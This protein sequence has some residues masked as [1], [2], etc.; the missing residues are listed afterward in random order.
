MSPLL[1]FVEH[2]LQEFA[3]AFMGTVYVFRLVWFFRRFKKPIELQ[4]PTGSRNTGRTLGVVYSLGIIALPWH[5]ESYRKKP[6]MYVQFALFHL[7]IATCITLSFLIPYAPSA[8]E[9]VS[10][11][12]FIQ[13]LCVIAGVIGV[14]R[15]L[16]RVTDKTMRAISA[17]DDYF[18]IVL[19]SLW[20]FLGA[21]VAPNTED[22]HDILVVY[23]VVTAFFLV[24][25]PFSKISHYLYYPIAR[26][27]LGRTMGHRGVFPIPSHWPTVGEAK[28]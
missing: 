22:L 23:F 4:P 1:H 21:I 17:P 11:V 19:L 2:P 9:S 18:S 13:A 8:L 14:Y 20:L 5:M 24:Y 25:V 26:F 28:R 12:R 15:F 7:G 10:V 6:W 3:L 16:R 27:Y